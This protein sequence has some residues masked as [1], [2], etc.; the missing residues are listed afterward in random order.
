MFAA[1]YIPDG[2]H[3]Q[4]RHFDDLQQRTTSPENAWRFLDVFADIEVETGRSRSQRQVILGARREPEN[5]FEQ[6]RLLAGLI[7]NSR[8]VP[9]DSANHL[10]PEQDPAGGTRA[11]VDGFLGTSVDVVGARSSGRG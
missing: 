3:E 9:L 7:K 5:C 4:W 10:A 8:L 6:S 1:R 2:T 11:E